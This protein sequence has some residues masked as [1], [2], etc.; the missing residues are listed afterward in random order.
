MLKR[1]LATAD[2]LVALTFCSAGAYA[3]AQDS[4]MLLTTSAG[5]IELELANS[6]A[7][8]SVNNFV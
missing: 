5:N 1:S 4:Y 7:P 6:K 8:V 3:A 2:T